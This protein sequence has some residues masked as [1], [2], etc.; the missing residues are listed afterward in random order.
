[1][2][3]LLRASADRASPISR[4]RP[5]PV[6]LMVAAAE[7]PVLRPQ[8]MGAA[9]LTGTATGV[10]VSGFKVAALG[11]AAALY[12]GPLALPELPGSELGPYVLVR[13]HRRHQCRHTA[14][15]APLPLRT[16]SRLHVEVLGSSTAQPVV[17]TSASFR[18]PRSR[19]ARRGRS[20]GRARLLSYY[21]PYYLPQS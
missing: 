12:A 15:P 4:L 14:P 16:P 21:L 18:C 7:E 13:P 9:A 8:L 5:R 10:A 19:M 2:L 1:M 6:P 3:V 11:L 17:C 20:Q